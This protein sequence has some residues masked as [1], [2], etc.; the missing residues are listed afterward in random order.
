MKKM[1]YGLVLGCA[2]YCGKASADELPDFEMPEYQFQRPN[3]LKGTS[4]TYN[5]R[6][7]SLKPLN[8][9]RTFQHNNVEDIILQ[10][11]NMFPGLEYK[12]PGTFNIVLFRF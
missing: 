7:V 11:E 4:K 12:S 10:E 1:L 3:H 6:P 9:Q 5:I 8:K 2:L